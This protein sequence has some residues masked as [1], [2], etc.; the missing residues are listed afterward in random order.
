MLIVVTYDI[1]TLDREGERR[2]RNVAKV[3]ENYGQRVQKSVFECQ[4][5]KSQYF[6]LRTELLTIIDPEQDTV[7]FYR[8]TAPH[9][10]HIEAYGTATSVDFEGP[11]I[12]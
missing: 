12:I 5:G 1:A 7:R 11:L 10:D 8:I 3:C 2:L 9:N 4:L 6:E